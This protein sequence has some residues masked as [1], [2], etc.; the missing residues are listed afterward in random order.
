[1]TTRAKELANKLRI[2][3]WEGMPTVEEKYD[4]AAHLDAKDA[5]DSAVTGDVEEIRRRTEQ[6]IPA[7]GLTYCEETQRKDLGTLLAIVQRQAGQVATLT[8]NQETIR[9][10]LQDGL[11]LKD[12]TGQNLDIEWLLGRAGTE[13][14]SRLRL[15][16]QLDAARAEVERLKER[17]ARDD[18]GVTIHACPAKGEGM[19]PCCGRTPFEVM[20]DRMTTNPALINCDRVR[21]QTERAALAQ[22][23]ARL[24]ERLRKMQHG[25]AEAL[26]MMAAEKQRADVFAEGVRLFWGDNGWNAAAAL[27]WKRKHGHLVG[28]GK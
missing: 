12:W 5:I 4:I 17:C 14:R 1:M 8:T 18:A 21:L 20:A 2:P 19:M 9:A 23:N 24:T 27:E 26:K 15:Q 22:E 25:E 28:D 16:Q 11:G 10:C 6:E 3:G 7:G 13:Y